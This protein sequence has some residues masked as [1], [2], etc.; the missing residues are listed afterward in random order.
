MLSMYRANPLYYFYNI[1]VNPKLFYSKVYFFKKRHTSI[2][3]KVWN[4]QKV[5][6]FPVNKRFSAKFLLS[7]IKCSIYYFHGFYQSVNGFERSH[8]KHQS[9]CAIALKQVSQTDLI[10]GSFYRKKKKI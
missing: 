1:S 8:H 6:M 2:Q 10:M 9:N 4:N 5:P 7:T 3:K